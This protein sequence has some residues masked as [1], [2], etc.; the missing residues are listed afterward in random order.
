[1]VRRELIVPVCRNH[2]RRHHLGTPPEHR[3][4]IER[5]LVSPMQILDHEDCGLDGGQFVAQR[6]EG[7]SGPLT[8][9][10]GLGKRT[11]GDRGDVD[12]RSERT[13]GTQAI[14]AAPQDPCSRT[15]SVTELPHQGGLPDTGL[16]GYQHQ[17]P[18]TAGNVSPTGLQQLEI[19]IA[20]Q[21]TRRGGWGAR[22]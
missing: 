3:H 13:G 14:T 6:G 9:R 2:Q 17:P 7:T 8:S 22:P 11:T 10:N 1:M 4:D 20:F 5:R 16:T 21:Q 15:P 12:E 18:V 19:R